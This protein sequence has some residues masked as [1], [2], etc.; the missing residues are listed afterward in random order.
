MALEQDDE[1]LML[2]RVVRGVNE[3]TGLQKHT[4]AFEVH[5]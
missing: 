4:Q 3:I 2:V 5:G 1:N